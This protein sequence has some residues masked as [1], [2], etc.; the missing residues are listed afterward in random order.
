M[1]V[2]QALQNGDATMLDQALAIQ[3]TASI[4]STVARLPVASVLPLLEEVLQRI[5]GKP[6]RIAALVRS[7]H[8][9]LRGLSVSDVPL[10][11][12][13]PWGK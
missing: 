8:T 11:M 4:V 2:W 12:L 6:V 1:N 9:N 7:L 3:D 5:Q 13:H 10:P